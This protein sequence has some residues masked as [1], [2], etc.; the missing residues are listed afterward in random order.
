MALRYESF[1][2]TGCLKLDFSCETSY[3][4]DIV[5][6]FFNIGQMPLHLAAVGGHFQIVQLLFHFG[7][8]VNAFV[9]CCKSSKN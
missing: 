9:S 3:L 4:F 2:L 6:I 1:C 8:N 7:A 5:F